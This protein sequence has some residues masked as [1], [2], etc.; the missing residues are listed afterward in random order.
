MPHRTGGIST[1]RRRLASS[2]KG[3]RALNLLAVAPFAGRPAEGRLITDARVVV[4]QKSGYL[5][6]YRVEGDDFVDVLAL[7]HGRRE[8]NEPG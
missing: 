1:A 8:E 6:F 5:L 3:L 7:G 2:T 4:F